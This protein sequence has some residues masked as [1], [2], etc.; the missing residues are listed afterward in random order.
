MW[1]IRTV[2][3]CPRVLAIAVNCQRDGCRC[4]WHAE[5][6][7]YPAVEGKRLVLGAGES[8]YPNRRAVRE[9]KCFGPIRTRKIRR[10]EAVGTTRPRNYRSRS[11][12][13]FT[14][15][16]G[17]GRSEQRR[18]ALQQVGS[19]VLSVGGRWQQQSKRE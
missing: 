14:G 4:S 5:D 10:D 8:E 15:W 9:S 17:V 6:L 18:R 12:C 2:A 16:L 11:A 1:H 3:I 7:I 19:F 13:G